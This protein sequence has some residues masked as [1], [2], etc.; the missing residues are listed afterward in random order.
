MNAPS[1]VPTFKVIPH[2]TAT[3]AARKAALDYHEFPLPGKTATALTKPAATAQDLA[4]AY[5]PGVAEPVRAIAA[6][7]D[8]AYRF[9]NKGNLVAVISEGWETRIAPLD[10]A[11]RQVLRERLFSAGELLRVNQLAPDRSIIEQQG[12]E[13]AELFG[14]KQS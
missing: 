1:L 11:S 13:Q 9:T 6:N 5:S 10:A 7:P 12:A 8:D 3:D 4:L 14:E 2:M